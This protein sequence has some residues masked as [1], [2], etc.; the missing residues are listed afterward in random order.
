M[1]GF[2]QDAFIL[3]QGPFKAR[4]HNIFQIFFSIVNVTE[5]GGGGSKK[6]RCR[7]DSCCV[8][9]AIAAAKLEEHCCSCTFQS[10]TLVFLFNQKKKNPSSNQISS[11]AWR[12]IE[13]QQTARRILYCTATRTLIISYSNIIIYAWKVLLVNSV[14]IFIPVGGVSGGA[15]S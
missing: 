15:D 2:P 9:G 11:P 13:I 4:S 10:C 14:V 7:R 3:R 1:Q 5:K 12:P 6:R 8:K